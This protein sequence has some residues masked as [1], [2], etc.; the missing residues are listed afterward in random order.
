MTPFQLADSAKA[1][2]TRTTVV[3]MRSPFG[4]FGKTRAPPLRFGSPGS[5]GQVTS[6]CP[7]PGS[8]SLH[9]WTTAVDGS[10]VTQSV[11]NRP[12]HRS[13]ML[14]R[15][16]ECEAVDRLLADVLVGQS[17]V[18]V[19]RGEAGVGKTALLRYVAEE[20]AGCRVARAAGV[21]SEMELP[22]AGLHQ[23]CAPIFDS[24]NR[25]PDPQRDA[26][27]VA[28][29]V[30]DGASP[31]HFLVALAALSLLADAAEA[32]PLV[33]LVDDA[34]WL[35]RASAQALACVARRRLA[36]R[37]AMVFAVR[38][39]SAADELA[40]FPEL[41][42]EGLAEREARALLGSALP[43]VLDERIRDRIVAETRGNPL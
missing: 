32:R 27:R 17:R 40:G 25:I 1:P 4:W 9:W 6:Q 39:S 11:V 13:W 12:P 26:L 42:V 24:L 30:Q 7:S 34:Q 22:F 21:Q 8:R 3:R 19:V 33:C 2:W 14:G 36:E 5:S 41:L 16:A 37:I 23:L 31:N 15:R 20:A 10:S 28:F 43:G 18:L 29:G 35:D 38:E